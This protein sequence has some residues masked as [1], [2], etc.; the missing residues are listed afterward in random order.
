MANKIRTCIDC[1]III[2][3][4]R[5]KTYRGNRATRCKKC[6]D[7]YAQ[8]YNR[9]YWQQNK[10]LYKHR[11][12]GRLGN[13]QDDKR[14]LDYKHNLDNAPDAKSKKEIIDGHKPLSNLKINVENQADYES[15]KEKRIRLEEEWGD[16]Y[17]DQEDW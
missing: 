9:V 7:E 10:D 16:E 4:K 2:S 14:F 12:I 6:Q 17:I 1:N 8:E 13:P 3:D 11:W 15:Y 5:Y